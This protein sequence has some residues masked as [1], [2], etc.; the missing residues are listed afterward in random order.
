M[1]ATNGI[2]ILVRDCPR[3]ASSPGWPAWSGRSASRRRRGTARASPP[4]SANHPHDS[5]RGRADHGGLVQH[6]IDPVEYT[7]RLC[8]P[9]RTQ[10]EPGRPVRPRAQDYP[11]VHPASDLFLHID[12]QGGERLIAWN[13]AAPQ[14]RKLWT[15]DESLHSGL[16]P[17][18]EASTVIQ[19]PPL[20]GL[21]A[22]GPSNELPDYSS[23]SGR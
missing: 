6:R 8:P 21:A 3:L 17:G 7:R 14:R 4:A 12:A 16:R 19:Y 9:G 15:I 13:R 23:R 2:E 5:G 10:V 20:P 1:T 18:S 22:R 11:E